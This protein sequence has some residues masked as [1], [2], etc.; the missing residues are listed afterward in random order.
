MYREIL[1]STALL[2]DGEKKRHPFP[3]WRLITGQTD[4][5]LEG[6]KGRY[7]HRGY[8]ITVGDQVDY[9]ISK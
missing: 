5:V 3:W 1:K 6:L 9:F 4:E 8:C 2:T 7:V